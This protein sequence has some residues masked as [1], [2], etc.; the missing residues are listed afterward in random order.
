[1]TRIDQHRLAILLPLLGRARLLALAEQLAAGLAAAPGFPETEL[2]DHLHR[3]KGGA[4][5]LGFTALA[6]DLAVAET[7]GSDIAVLAQQ[8]STM[9]PLLL[10]AL[11]TG[12]PNDSPCVVP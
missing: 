11:K 7:G 5:S 12:F 9:V 3:L 1:M 2:S 4:A 8:A 10:A 6:A